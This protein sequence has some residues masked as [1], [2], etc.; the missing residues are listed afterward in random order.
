MLLVRGSLLVG[1]RNE[2]VIGQLKDLL[3]IWLAEH[4]P[5]VLYVDGDR[6]VLEGVVRAFAEVGC[7]GNR[8]CSFSMFGTGVHKLGDLLSNISGITDLVFACP[9]DR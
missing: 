1:R 3:V 6:A 7:L 2:V 4:W 5:V 9:N 8:C